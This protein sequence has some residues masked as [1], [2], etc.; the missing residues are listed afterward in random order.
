[1]V[2]T[3]F[4]TVITSFGR[5]LHVDNQLQ[6]PVRAGFYM[7]ATNQLQVGYNQLQQVYNQIQQG[8]SVTT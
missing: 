6:V 4:N 7:V 8:S 2:T 3:E 5:V 1:M